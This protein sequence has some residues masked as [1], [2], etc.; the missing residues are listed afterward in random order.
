LP[1][2]SLRIQGTTH[3]YWMYQLAPSELLGLGLLELERFVCL[4]GEGRANFRQTDVGLSQDDGEDRQPSGATSRRMP[5]IGYRYWVP[6]IRRTA[7]IKN[8]PASQPPLAAEPGPDG[9]RHLA[10]Y[11]E[12]W[13]ISW[14]KVSSQRLCAIDIGLGFDHLPSLASWA[15]VERPVAVVASS[16]G[17]RLGR[18]TGKT[19]KMSMLIFR[20]PR[21]CRGDGP[22]VGERGRAGGGG[23]CGSS[24]ACGRRAA[25]RRALRA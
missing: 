17:A 18:S 10:R 20:A 15:S 25:A 24:S 1:G 23:W 21:A 8:Q 13:N 7:R 2:L 3:E 6:Q 14:H 12:S 4:S 16:L 22:G 5:A 19:L 11:G 9:E